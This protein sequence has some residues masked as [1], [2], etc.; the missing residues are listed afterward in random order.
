VTL[1][2]HGDD[3]AVMF[4]VNVGVL[5]SPDAFE[6]FADRF[7]GTAPRALGRCISPSTL[8]RHSRRGATMS[9]EAALVHD[10][11]RRRLL[12]VVGAA[13]AVAAGRSSERPR[14]RRWR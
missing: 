6:R 8:P 4:G 1:Y 5:D 10:A 11:A 2:S 13:A 9:M 7:F 12:L 3:H 14:R